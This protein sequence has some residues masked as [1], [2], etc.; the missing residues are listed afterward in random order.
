MNW[1]A[2]GAIGEIVGAAA[3]VATLVYLSVQ[4]RSANRQAEIEALRHSWDGLNQFCDQLSRP[5]IASIVNRGRESLANLDPDERLIFEH[6][7]IRLLNTMESW[8][9][10]IDRTSPPGP[11][12]DTQM[13]NLA[14]IAEGYF[15]FPGTRELWGVIGY[16]FVPIKGLVDGALGDGGPQE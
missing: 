9:L 8:H 3:V 5:D 16:Y 10:Q 7:H 15:G 2:M 11:Y 4:I 6:I 12:R 13:G 1:D 14:G